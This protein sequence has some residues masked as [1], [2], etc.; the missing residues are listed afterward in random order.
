MSLFFLSC[1]GC[2]ACHLF[3]GDKILA[4]D[5]AAANPLFEA[6]DPNLE[7]ADAPL[8]GVT[9]T[10]RAEEL[11]RLASR[12][13]IDLPPLTPPLIK[14]MCFERATEALTV[15]KLLA[16]LRDA[17]AIADAHI[18]ILDF[19]RAGVP[20]GTIAF[21]RAGLSSSGLWR[22]SVIYGQGRSVP[23]WVKARITVERTWVEAS[24]RL[25]ANQPVEAG[26]LALRTGPRFPFDPAPLD[27]IE[28]AR[29]RRPLRTIPPGSPVYAAE[30]LAPHVVERGDKVIVEASSGGAI[31]NFDAT[32]ESAG[33]TGEFILI[34]NPSNGRSFRARIDDKGKVSVGR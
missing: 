1:L 5:L 29:G 8:A 27:R 11:R 15:D 28:L 30:L 16:A 20:K 9:R 4:R 19:S 6:L 13:S 7:I 17:V 18:E 12:H 3:E 21:T 32:A 22:G 31:L 2:F 26:Q 10:L 24:Q 25:P 34:K 14:D 33:S 23:V